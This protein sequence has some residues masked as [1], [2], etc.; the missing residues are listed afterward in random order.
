MD[1]DEI[2][3]RLRFRLASGEITSDEYDDILK[4]INPSQA[5]S[6]N[7]NKS[8]RQ[9]IVVELESEASPYFL[10]LWRGELDLVTT[11]WIW[12]AFVTII[13]AIAL[14][15]ISS[16]MTDQ[17]QIFIL[18]SLSLCWDSFITIAVIRSATKYSRIY[19]SKIWGWAAQLIAIVGI[20]VD[21][22]DFIS[23]P[24]VF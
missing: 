7:S 24:T 22:V 9:A 3:N 16:I 18:K 15:A 13:I 21:I 14:V 10:R 2:L 4:K 5:E 8:R 20:L 1:S 12:G 23:R 17:S 11:F 19:P 6:E